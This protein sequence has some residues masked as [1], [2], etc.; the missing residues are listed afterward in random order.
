MKKS[1]FPLMIIFFFL[2]LT[3][4]AQQQGIQPSDNLV[5][6]PKGQQTVAP[7]KTKVELPT[8]IPTDNPTFTATIG[9]KPSSTMVPTQTPFTYHSP[10]PSAT[11]ECNCNEDFTCD[12]F[13]KQKDAQFCFEQCYGINTESWLGLDPDQNGKVCEELP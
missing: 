13:S 10:T 1:L 7:S 6:T 9:L 3:S 5:E 2:T 8:L 12:L 4:C 11:P